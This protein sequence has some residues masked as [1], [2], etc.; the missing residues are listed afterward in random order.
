MATWELDGR[1]SLIV[2]IGIGK[3]FGFLVGLSA[4]FIM[5]MI[6]PEV[7]DM[8][9]WAMLLWY[10]TFGAIIGVFGVLTYHP[11]LKMPMPWWFRAP[12]IG[13]WLNFVLTLFIYEDIK[14]FSTALFGVDGLFSSPFWFVGEG[15]VVGL[16]IGYLATALAGEGKETVAEQL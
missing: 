6:L 14:A 12:F 4:F 16:L 7:S 2:R 13:G 9:R 3:L 15:V 5:P 8:L 10:I 11:I 1:P